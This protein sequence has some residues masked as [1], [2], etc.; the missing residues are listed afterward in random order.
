MAEAKV[1]AV[2]PGPDADLIQNLRDFA[3]FSGT[4][5]CGKAADRIL[6]LLELLTAS[7]RALVKQEDK[8]CQMVEAI[9]PL[10]EQL[11]VLQ[12]IIVQ[13]QHKPVISR[14]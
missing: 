1:W 4:P 11:K 9:E 5:M 2:E 14:L 6:E 13:Y 10:V 12:N 7:G 3:A 8:I